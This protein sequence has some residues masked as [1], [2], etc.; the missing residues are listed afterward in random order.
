MRR[1]DY[2]A[3]ITARTEL[4]GQGFAKVLFHRGR[5]VGATIAGD[6]ACELIAPLALAVSQEL[7]LSALRRWI[8]PHPTLSEILTAI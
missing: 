1:A 4:K 8:I 7:D 5:L 3:N 2:G 6:D